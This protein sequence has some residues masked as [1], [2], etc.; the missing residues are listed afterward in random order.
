MADCQ[1]FAIIGAMKVGLQVTNGILDFKRVRV[2]GMCCVENF[3]R[4][5]LDEKS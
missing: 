2:V 3:V 4:P 1:K 5:R